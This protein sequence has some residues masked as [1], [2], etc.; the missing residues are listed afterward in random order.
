MSA[1]SFGHPHYSH[2]LKVNQPN[3]WYP[4]I[5]NQHCNVT[6]LASGLSSDAII[7][8]GYGRC[9]WAEPA[10]AESL[11]QSALAFRQDRYSQLR[12][13]NLMPTLMLHLTSVQT[14]SS[15]STVA[16]KEANGA[17]SREADGAS[18]GTTSGNVSLPS[19]A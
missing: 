16:P 1:P 15:Q 10:A 18:D 7:I 14:D 13:R 3:S 12:S 8:A 11:H 2:V 4:A 19:R 9:W 5:T 6:C 17:P